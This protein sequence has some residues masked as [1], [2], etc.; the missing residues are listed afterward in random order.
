MLFCE[1]CESSAG[2]SAETV[3][4]QI[5]NG[6]IECPVCGH[7]IEFTLAQLQRI[8]D[9]VLKETHKGAA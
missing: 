8:Y 3:F 5:R 1:A 4:R 6:M 7:L 2:D 9:A